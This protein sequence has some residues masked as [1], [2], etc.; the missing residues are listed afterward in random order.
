M[1]AGDILDASA[2]LLNDP[3]KQKFTNTVQIPYLN[4]ALRM[5]QEEM[6]LSNVPATNVSS[7]EIAVPA[8]TF[9]I[10]GDSGINL[11]T[12]LI[13]IQQ[14]WSRPGGT[15][16]SYL[17]MTKKEFL[18]HYLFSQEFTYVI[19][20]AYME[21]I[22]QL[23]PATGPTDIKIDYIKS[24]FDVVDATSDVINI[25]NGMTYL[26]FKT[27]ALCSRYIGENPTRADQLDIEAI[28]GLDRVLGISTKGRQA[29]TTR[30]R[31]FRA[32]FKNRAGYARS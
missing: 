27:A 30:R 28:T 22:I 3:Q 29:I 24:L 17:P 7:A 11:P 13:E 19:I 32:A 9:N 31:P 15:G 5:L 20:W 6:E 2:V 16:N 8:A 21:E 12:G 14:L 26:S 23:V 1:T 10:G 18:S 25:I 4:M